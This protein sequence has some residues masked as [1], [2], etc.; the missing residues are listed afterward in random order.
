M[1]SGGWVGF[2]TG[3]GGLL[4]FRL[5]VHVSACNTRFEHCNNAVGALGLAEC[6]LECVLQ[7]KPQQNASIG[8]LFYSRTPASI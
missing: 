8:L 1:L 6:R 5:D 3:F 2:C 4:L 7:A